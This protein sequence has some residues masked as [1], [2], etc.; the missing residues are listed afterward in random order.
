[1]ETTET[2][3]AD[4]RGHVLRS[5]DE[6]GEAHV[7]RY[8]RGSKLL[9]FELSDL[10][11]YLRTLSTARIPVKRLP[12]GLFC[13]DII[14]ESQDSSIQVSIVNPVVCCVLH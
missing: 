4:R 3:T 5:D 8:G 1:M 10:P 6:Y 11:S 7:V 9:E 12:G 14:W 2:P 13:A